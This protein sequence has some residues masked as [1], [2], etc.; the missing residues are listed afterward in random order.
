M[1]YDAFLLVVSEI[2]LGQDAISVRGNILR[3]LQHAQDTETL[4]FDL[5]NL[6]AAGKHH[7]PP[8]SSVSIIQDLHGFMDLYNIKFNS[9][10]LNFMTTL[11]DPFQV[12]SI[13]LMLYK[14]Y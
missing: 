7:C 4:N 5:Q 11:K 6:T 12:N 14:W 9:I 1:L 2:G 3:A 13:N 8:Y 10:L